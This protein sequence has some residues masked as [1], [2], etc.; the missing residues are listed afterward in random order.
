MTSFMVQV[1]MFITPVLYPFSAVPEQYRMAMSLANP[2]AAIVEESRWCF[3]GESTIT[4][5]QLL[6][7][8]LTTAVVLACGVLLYQRVERTVMDTI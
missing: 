2:L 7:S 3:L 6:A 8:L 5:G 4:P 1:S